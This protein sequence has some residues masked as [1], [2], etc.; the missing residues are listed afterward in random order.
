MAETVIGKPGPF[1]VIDNDGHGN[2]DAPISPPR[3]RY[4]CS[5]YETCLDLAA[6][7]NWDSFSCRGCS[8][9]VNESLFWRAAQMEK[10]DALVS[11][12]CTIPL[13]KGKR[14]ALVEIRSGRKIGRK[15]VGS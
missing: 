9:E 4:D 12:I 11:E 6:A 1:Q 7:L 2:P 13:L 10:R 8:G 5:H 3:R 15:I 14:P